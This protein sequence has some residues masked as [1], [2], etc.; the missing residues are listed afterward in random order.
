MPKRL[1]WDEWDA[2]EAVLTTLTEAGATLEKMGA[3]LGVTRERARQLLHYFGLIG[4]HHAAR[5]EVRDARRIGQAEQHWTAPELARLETQAKRAGHT[6]ERWL[7]G[8]RSA[9]CRWHLSVDGAP[10]RI[11]Q[12]QAVF[13]GAYHRVNCAVPSAAYLVICR[14]GRR[15]LYGPQRGER[16]SLYVRADGQPKAGHERVRPWLSYP[17]ATA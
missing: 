14:D 9:V 6:V 10:V 4:R 7:A 12:P 5:A 15:V 8:Q 11:V 13:A 2:R 3:Q 1:T 16:G 17:G